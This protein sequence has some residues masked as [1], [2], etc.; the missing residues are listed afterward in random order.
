M[1]IF[2]PHPHYFTLKVKTKLLNITIYIITTINHN[3][4]VYVDHGPVYLPR[5]GA[6]F[7][8]LNNHLSK[9]NCLVASSS[10][11]TIFFSITG[12]LAVTGTGRAS[13][14]EGLSTK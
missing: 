12:W 13:V 7:L 3:N 14:A 9:K 6:R 1:A 2:R 10:Y 4:Y 8:L 5:T 11:E